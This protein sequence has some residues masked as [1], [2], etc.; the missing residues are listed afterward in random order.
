MLTIKLTKENRKQ[1]KEF[2]T[3]GVH[4]AMLIRRANIILAL[5]TSYG[6]TIETDEKIAQKCNCSRQTVDTVRKD[7]LLSE[8]TEKFL[9]R[10]K[11]ETPP[12]E[13]KI[14]GEVEA[15]IVALACSQ[16]P[17]GFAKWSLNLLAKKAVENKIIDSIS[18]MSVQRVL[19]KHRL[20]LI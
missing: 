12:V 8:S 20:N 17:D 10:K 9:Q 14:T 18:H 3:K 4:S 16:A 6:R 1:L 7:F 19:K 5:D 15:R 13:P 2:I 11:R